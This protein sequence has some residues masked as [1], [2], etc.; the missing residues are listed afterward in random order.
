VGA[1]D[2]GADVV[3]VGRWVIGRQV[4]VVDAPGSDECMS[5][6]LLVRH[7]LNGECQG[8]GAATTARTEPQGRT[9][10][11]EIADTNATLYRAYLLKEQL[12]EVF[13]VK[14]THGRQLLAGWLSW[15]SHSRIPEFAALARSIRRFGTADA[16]DEAR[17][18]T[19]TAAYHGHPFD[20]SQAV[21]ELLQGF[22]NGFPDF[23]IEPASIRHMDDG[24]MVEG[25]I[26]GTHD[27]EWAGIA[28]T[29]RR[30]KVPVVGI[31]EFDED[32]LLCEKGHL[33]MASPLKQIGAA[34]LLADAGQ[35]EWSV[36]KQ[37]S[38]NWTA[39]DRPPGRN[40]PASPGPRRCPP[41]RPHQAQ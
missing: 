6:D 40:S 29:A 24:V 33:D 27:G 9:S 23:H 14:G 11:A 41:Y 8:R 38:P 22:M 7:G 28:P 15:A 35:P 20:G 3:G 37:I 10:L 21:R 5:V 31:F 16:I 2:L 26:T 18:I 36:S 19:L 1:A 12:R 25:L 30:I 17:P 4:G 34:G 39:T 32:R 13:R